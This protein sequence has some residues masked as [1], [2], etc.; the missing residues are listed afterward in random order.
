MDLSELGSEIK[1]FTAQA[2]SRL[3]AI[4]QKI[5]APN[6]GGGGSGDGTDIARAICESQEYKSFIQNNGRSTG[7]IPVGSFFTKTTIVN[8]TGQNHPLV[9]PYIRPGI[10]DPGQQSITIADL[11]PRIPTTTNL[12]EFT[13]ENSHTDATAIQVNEGDVKGESALGFALLYAPVR[14]VASW[15]PCSTQIL[16]D[17]PALQNYVSSRLL[18]FNAL[19]VERELLLGSGVGTEINGL[20]TQATAFDT[21]QVTVATDTYIDVLGLALTQCAASLFEPDGIVLNPKDWSRIRA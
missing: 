6:G 12:I 20:V 7:R 8:A 21:T 4:E 3:L 19:K 17:A 2:N 14:T 18:Y 13:S 15:I 11:M 5:T 9:P 10:L 16:S 1:D